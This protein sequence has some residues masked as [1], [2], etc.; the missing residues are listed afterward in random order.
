[1]DAELKAYLDDMRREMGGIKREMGDI[2]GEMGD[3]RREMG[4]I[5]REMGDIKREMGD[6]KREMGDMKRDL[7]AHTE[8]V[9]TRLLTEFWK[10][11]RTSDARYRQSHSMVEA[12]DHRVQ[13]VED[14]VAELERK[15]AS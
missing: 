9:E 13:V 12:M 1:M 5:K 10:W 6:I 3:M 14:R 4:D 11:A 8:E 7:M 2:K 15:R